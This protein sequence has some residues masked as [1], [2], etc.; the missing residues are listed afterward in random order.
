MD[1][2][3]KYSHVFSLLKGV[4]RNSDVNWSAR[5]PA[6]DDG[7]ASLSITHGRNDNLV[8]RCHAPCHCPT[9]SILKALGLTMQAIFAD[10][11][12][13][14]FRTDRKIVCTYRYDNPDGSYA[15]ECVRWEP[16]EFS[17]RRPNPLYPHSDNS[18]YLWTIEGLPRILYRLP[19]LLASLRDF[20][21]REVF[22]LEG[23]KDVETARRLGLVAT[24]SPFGAKNWQESYKDWFVGARVNIVHDHDKWDERSED[25][26]GLAHAIKV[27]RSL[28][29]VAHTVKVIALPL[30]A[31]REKYDFTNWYEDLP[32]KT[33]A[34]KYL[35]DITKA[36]TPYYH[37]WE[38]A[39]DFQR[40]QAKA[41]REIAM[42]PIDL[43]RLREIVGAS[44]ATVFEGLQLDSLAPDMARLAAALE[45]FATHMT[46]LH[47]P[48]TD[49]YH[50][51]RAQSA[52][53]LAE[54]Q[55]LK[56]LGIC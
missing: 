35:W 37:G 13:R 11:G 20:P 2:E 36:V 34:K 52:A 10:G 39:S 31:G 30:P 9:E 18:K 3:T 19:E 29:A 23:E 8:M 12:K 26:P 42:Q 46:T 41:A 16:K 33:Q 27:A 49:I 32:E 1:F 48:R 45:L 56:E 53:E 28:A 15:F 14:A 38:Y 43:N 50:R 4:V 47:G 17:Y 40:L 6:H 25:R 5:C 51:P 22:L 21:T 55:L 54:E 44:M 24:T 7:R